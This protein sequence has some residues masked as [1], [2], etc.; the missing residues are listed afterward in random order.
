[1]L[2]T[3]IGANFVRTRFKSSALIGVP[4]AIVVLLAGI[5][6]TKTLSVISVWSILIFVLETNS[7]K[8]SAVIITPFATASSTL[9]APQPNLCVLTLLGSVTTAVEYLSPNILF[10]S[11]ATKL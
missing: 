7:C 10:T 3:K 4:A 6:K 8:R 9:T 5:A 1:M 2:L 11:T